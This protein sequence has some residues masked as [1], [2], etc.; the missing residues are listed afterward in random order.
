MY[1]VTDPRGFTGAYAY[2]GQFT[3][4]CERFLL[5]LLRKRVGHTNCRRCHC[6]NRGKATTLVFVTVRRDYYL[7]ADRARR[8]TKNRNYRLVA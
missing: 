1:L 5:Q 7:V 2:S 4:L 3:E 8:F 6:Q